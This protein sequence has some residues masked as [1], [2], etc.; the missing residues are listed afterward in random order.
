MPTDIA[1][2]SCFG[3]LGF[4][5]G[6]IGGIGIIGGNGQNGLNGVGDTEE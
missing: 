1:V 5:V 6:I 3:L 4:E 2:Y